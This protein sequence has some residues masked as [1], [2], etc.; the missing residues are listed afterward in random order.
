MGKLTDEELEII[1]SDKRRGRAIDPYVL[2]ERVK[3]DGRTPEQI[4]KAANVGKGMTRWLIGSKD[5][6]A[7]VWV[8]ERIRLA[9]RPQIR[10]RYLYEKPAEAREYK[11]LDDEQKR[12]FF[13]SAEQ[14]REFEVYDAVYDLCNKYSFSEV[15]DALSEI[16]CRY[17]AYLENA[18][19]TLDEVL[20]EE[21][22]GLPEVGY[23]GEV[24]ERQA[25][26]N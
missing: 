4:D 7:S 10:A 19:L 9:L 22:R 16:D 11:F 5:H 13:L 14:K 3:K 23:N 15:K 18:G 26:A 21:S 17:T 6:L 24:I 12:E 2:Y 8:I 1:Y 20:D 25:V